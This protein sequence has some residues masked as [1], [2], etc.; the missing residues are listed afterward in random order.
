MKGVGRSIKRAWKRIPLARRKRMHALRAYKALTGYRSPEEVR[1]AFLPEMG[2]RAQTY[3]R[4]MLHENIP[5]LRGLLHEP[6]LMP[7]PRLRVLVE[8][9]LKVADGFHHLHRADPLYNLI[10]VQYQYRIM[11]LHDRLGSLERAKKLR[12]PEQAHGIGEL[13]V[14]VELA[15]LQLGVKENVQL[16][17]KQ[18]VLNILL[19][20][21][22]HVPWKEVGK[23]LDVFL[24]GRAKSF[25][26][27]YWKNNQELQKLD[28]HVFYLQD[29][30]KKYPGGN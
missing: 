11:E 6:R 14:A 3:Y 1:R 13:R 18:E 29:L 4:E 26:K 28:T 5:L 23:K 20:T 15:Y 12:T 17:E 7:H 22:S 25:L 27:Y 21:L 9:A 30:R 8:D 2:L 19:T 24:K 16:K 10:L